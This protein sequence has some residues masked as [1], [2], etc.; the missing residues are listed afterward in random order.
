MIVVQLN[1]GLGNQ[2]FQYAAAKALS[3]HHNVELKIDDSQFRRTTI[4]ELEVPRISEL[5]NF[6][7]ITDRY[8]DQDELAKFQN[9]HK[10]L[11]KVLPR[12]RQLIYRERFYH[13]DP[14]FFKCNKN[15]LLKGAWQSPKYFAG[16]EDVVRQTYALNI[17]KMT[18]VELF[19]DQLKSQQSVAVHIRRNDYLR[20]PIILEWH[21]VMSANYY[22]EALNRLSSSIA[23]LKIYYFTDDPIWVKQELVPVFG[24]ELV[25]SAISQ[26]HLEDFYLM[27]HCRHN[28]IANSSFSWWSAWMNSNPGKIVIGP[29]NWFDHGPKDT[30]DLFPKSWIRI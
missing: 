5:A 8:I 9:Q 28:I 15:I 14:K 21:G 24:G 16:Y 17:G 12:N 11:K 10:W 26:T 7:A 20:L 13:F 3:L 4:S 23:D 6:P 27:S 22:R 2:M 25:S 1:G 19:K 30:Q 29:S 18:S